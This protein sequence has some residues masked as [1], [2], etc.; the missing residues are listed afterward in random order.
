MLLKSKPLGLQAGGPLAT[1]DAVCLDA[2][3][4]LGRGRRSNGVRLAGGV[5][6][7]VVQ[8]ALGKCYQ[9]ITRN[10]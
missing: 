2:L 1:E 10:M 4:L 6:G 7:E 5:F 9:L 8:E 3:C